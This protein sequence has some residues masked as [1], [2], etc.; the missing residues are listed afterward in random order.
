MK[1]NSK[2]REHQNSEERKTNF[3][4]DRRNFIKKYL[5]KCISVPLERAIVEDNL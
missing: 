2:V 3:K 4:K 5:P 1:V